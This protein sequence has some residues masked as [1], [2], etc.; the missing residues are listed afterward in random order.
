MRPIKFTFVAITVFFSLIFSI[1][2]SAQGV[3]LGTAVTVKA[4]VYG[5]EK[6]DRTLWLIG[7]NKNILEI[8]VS[9]DAKNF[10]QL[11]IGDIVN[12]TYYE[13]IALY[14]GT[15]DEQPDLKT[16]SM[17]VRAA[18]GDTPAGVAVEV[19]DISATVLSIDREN[20]LIT[21]KGPSGNS[22]TTYVDESVK[23]FDKLKV[24]DVI[25]VA[26]TKALAVDVELL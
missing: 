26:Y 11:K 23:Y 8:E 16:D 25:H 3:E 5:I 4:E 7:P 10:N 2:L 17:I 14:L 9:K 12:I 1:S 24:N 18:E 13:S 21:L 22:F 6:I 15:T 19:A 20:R